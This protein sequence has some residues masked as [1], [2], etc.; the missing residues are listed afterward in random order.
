MQGLGP[1][2]IQAMGIEVDFDVR[3]ASDAVIALQAGGQVTC[4]SDHPN[5]ISE[6]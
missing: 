5:H 1:M 4:Q 3:G 6:F 2:S